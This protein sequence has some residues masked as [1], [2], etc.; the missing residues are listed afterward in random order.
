MKHS[1]HKT[2]STEIKIRF[3]DADPAGIMFFGN[4]FALAHDVF[5]EF[6]EA[7]GIGWKKWFDKPE[8]FVPIRHVECEYT[9][10]FVPGETYQV[11]V[12][13]ES[14]STSTFKL[15]Y[16]FSKGSTTHAVVKTAH[17]FADYEKKVKKAIPAELKSVLEAYVTH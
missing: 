4:I 16:V 14:I 15:K 17:T 1:A 5:E 8:H 6:I 7:S 10:P 11:Q 12:S 13:V 3:R 2:F 9:A